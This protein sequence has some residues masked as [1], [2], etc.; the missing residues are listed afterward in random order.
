MIPTQSFALSLWRGSR[1]RAQHVAIAPGLDREE[2]DA[3]F[4]EGAR[5]REP[6]APAADR[7]PRGRR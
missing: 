1:R 7:G 6:R 3:G 5:N 2:Y 4:A